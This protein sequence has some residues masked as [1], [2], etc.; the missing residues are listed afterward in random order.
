DPACRNPDIAVRGTAAFADPHAAVK[1]RRLAPRSIHLHTALDG[2]AEEVAVICRNNKVRDAQRRQTAD[3]LAELIQH[4]VHVASGLVL[5]LRALAMLVDFLRRD[6]HQ[7][8]VLNLI[9]EL[10]GWLPQIIELEVDNL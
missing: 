4:L 1:I 8:R 9:S 10:P 6:Q 3:A 5:T 2:L 7:V